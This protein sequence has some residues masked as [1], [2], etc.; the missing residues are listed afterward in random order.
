MKLL[1]LL[2]SICVLLVTSAKAEDVVTPGDF[3]IEPATL[4]NLGFEWKIAGDDN[5]NAKVG[6]SYRQEGTD[7]WNQAQP[8]LRIGDE[9]VWRSREYLEYWTPR[10]FAGS[11]FG[12]SPGHRYE[13]RFEM[14]DP[15]G[16]NGNATKVVIVKTRDVPKSYNEGKILHVYPPDYQGEKEEPAFTGLLEAYYGP[17]LGDWDVVHRRPVEPGTTILVHAGLYK[18]NRRDYVNPYQIPF[19]GSYV[20]T[21]DG[22]AEKPITIK[23]AGDGEVIFDGDNVFKLFDVMAADHTIFEGITVRN[24]EIAFYAGVKDVLGCSDLTVRNCRLEDVGIGIHTDWA[25][26]KNF[27]IADNIMIGRDDHYRLN[28]WS[29]MKTYGTSPLNSYYGV[30]V[31]G[32][33][34]VICH[35]K[36]SFFHDGVCVSTY[37]IPEEDQDLKCVSIDIYNNDIFLVVDD[38]IESDGGAHNIRVMNNRG[39]NAA[40]R[41]LSAQPMFGGP[42]YFIGNLIYH[43]PFGGAIKTGGANP[44]GVLVYHNTFIAENNDGGISNVHYRNNLFFGTDHPQRSLFRMQ[45]YTNYSTSD[46]NGYRPNQNDRPIFTWTAPENQLRQYDDLP[47]LKEFYTLDE[48]RKATGLEQHGI[49]VD[50]DIFGN[51]QLPDPASPHLVYLPEM[52]NFQLKP[53]SRAIDAGVLL[54]NINDDFTGKAPDLGALEYGKENPIYGPR[55]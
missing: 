52:V 41:G 9:K 28:G 38:F 18:A 48:F 47:P 20:L 10:M 5:H 26:S 37:G 23:A 51:V 45:T 15:D 46:Y 11:I 34:H 43:V 39:F 25:G 40:H 36:I 29:G 13:C 32:Q 3:I 31:Y 8:M 22:T 21:I 14:T 30:K 6:V 42:V 12:L 17:G 4:N 27:Y 2:S 35:N 24:T 1:L 53:K 16:V 7:T 50:V 54:L 19:F 44:A 49:L 33:G 55:K